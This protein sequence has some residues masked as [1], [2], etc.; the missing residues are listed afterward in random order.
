[1]EHGVRHL[2]DREELVAVAGMSQSKEDLSSSIDIQ[3]CYLMVSGPEYQY[4]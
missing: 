1:V 4:V 2:L 3:T